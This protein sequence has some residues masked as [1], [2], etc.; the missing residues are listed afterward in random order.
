MDAKTELIGTKLAELFCESIPGEAQC[1]RRISHYA[2]C[3]PNTLVLTLV[4]Y[5]LRRMHSS[6]VRPAESREED[7]AGVC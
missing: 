5:H 2:H 3:L 4:H 7:E 6:N 1:A